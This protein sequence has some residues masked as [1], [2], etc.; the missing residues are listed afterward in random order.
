MNIVTLEFYELLKRLNA[1]IKKLYIS[2]LGDAM[3]L[4]FSAYIHLPSIN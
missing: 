4:R 3:K 2:A 1:D